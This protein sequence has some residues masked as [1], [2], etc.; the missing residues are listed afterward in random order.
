MLKIM[1]IKERDLWEMN[2]IE[3]FGFPKELTN[4]W[5]DYRNQKIKERKDVE[6]RDTTTI[7]SLRKGES[8]YLNRLW[9]E[10]ILGGTKVEMRENG[11]KLINEYLELL[12]ERY[13]LGDYLNLIVEVVRINKI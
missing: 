5:I 9:R 8:E 2:F 3:S 7:D 13:L 12:K 11:E 6:I 10:R 4:K 1:N